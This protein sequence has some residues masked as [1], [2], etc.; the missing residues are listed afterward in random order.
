MS[1]FN[2]FVLP[3]FGIVP[4]VALRVENDLRGALNNEVAQ[5]DFGKTFD[6]G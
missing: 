5:L 6:I 3:G 4:Q 2:G 1:E